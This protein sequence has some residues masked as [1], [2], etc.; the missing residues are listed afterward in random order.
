MNRCYNIVSKCFQTNSL[1]MGEKKE[2]N[3]FQK[4]DSSV[5]NRSV[6]NCSISLIM[7]KSKLKW[8]DTLNTC[9][10]DNYQQDKRLEIL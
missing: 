1:R 3:S 8:N 2:L 7:T 6:K 10:I 9:Q 4:K 5:A